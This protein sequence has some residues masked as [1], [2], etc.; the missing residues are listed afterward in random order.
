MTD[1][2]PGVPVLPGWQVLWGRVY[3]DVM[4]GS[5]TGVG[6]K[7]EVGF[8]ARYATSCTARAVGAQLARAMIARQHAAVAK[9]TD[10]ERA[11]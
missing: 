7:R 2:Y 11:P 4:T 10:L 6:I 3:A 8:A 9:K 1:R 5:L